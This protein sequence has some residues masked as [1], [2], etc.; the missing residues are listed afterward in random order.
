MKKAKGREVWKA[1]M[2]SKKAGYENVVFVYYVFAKNAAQAEKRGFELAR[3]E[4]DFPQ[5]YCAAALFEHY[6]Y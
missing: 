6:V 5:P 1:R 2:E 4:E 3:Q